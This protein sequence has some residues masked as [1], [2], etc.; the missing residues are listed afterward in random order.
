MSAYGDDDLDDEEAALDRIADR[1]RDDPRADLGYMPAPPPP[2]PEV[3]PT[4][5][6]RSTKP[7]P[8]AGHFAIT[9]VPGEPGRPEE[10]GGPVG[11]ERVCRE[12]RE[13]AP[14]LH[15]DPRSSHPARVICGGCQGRINRDRIGDARAAAPTEPRGARR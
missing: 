11:G 6:P 9:W 2:P 10:R 12:C 14:V 7:P 15:A 5:Q 1:D 4:L 3:H 8:G 13:P